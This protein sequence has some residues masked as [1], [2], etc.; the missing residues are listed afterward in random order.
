[1]AEQNKIVVQLE[2]EN[3]NLGRKIHKLEKQLLSQNEHSTQQT[4]H[5]HCGSVD[6]VRIQIKHKVPGIVLMLRSLE[7]WPECRELLRL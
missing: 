5:D 2:E 6:E 3:E 7:I 1:M 4:H